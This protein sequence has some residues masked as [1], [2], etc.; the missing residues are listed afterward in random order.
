MHFVRG[1][2]VCVRIPEI[3]RIWIK[4]HKYAHKIRAMHKKNTLRSRVFFLTVCVYIVQSFL[5]NV[6]GFVL[7][8]KM[9]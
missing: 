6:S 8:C 9:A 3:R 4:M 7:F 1:K 2:T 5:W